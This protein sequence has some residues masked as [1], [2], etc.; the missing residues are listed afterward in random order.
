MVGDPRQ[1]VHALA[2]GPLDQRVAAQ[3]PAGARVGQ[4]PLGLGAGRGAPGGAV[5]ALG[6]LQQ[7]RLGGGGAPAGGETDA[8]VGEFDQA[9]AQRGLLEVDEPHPLAG[10]QV[11]AGTR[12]AVE[13]GVA[14]RPRQPVHQ[15]VEFAG[16][17]RRR[18]HP[19]GP[20]Q[21]EEGGGVAAGGRGPGGQGA[22]VPR[23]PGGVQPG[24]R[25]G[26]AHD[27]VV[28]RRAVFHVL[29]DQHPLVGV[30]GQERGDHRR[31][32]AGR[33]PQ[34]GHLARVALVRVGALD[35]LL[36][37]H[38]PGGQFEAPHARARAAVQSPGPAGRTQPGL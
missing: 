33:Q 4:V 34:R 28:R 24:Q 25:G 15:R 7:R 23:R 20:G 35:G 16:R 13:Q 21:G 5:G 26:V 1:V 6:A 22:R 27:P 17:A 8:Q 9:V 12:V 11:V 30:G 37:D 2:A 3:Q 14:R 32:G 19:Q 36:D 18:H 31:F 29:Q 10:V 38:R